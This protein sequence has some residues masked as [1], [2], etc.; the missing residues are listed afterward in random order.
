MTS[1]PLLSPPALRRVGTQR[2]VLGECPLWD[3][4]TGTLW[5]IDIRAPAL[6]RLDPQ[7]DAVS[8]WPLPELVGSLFRVVL[9]QP[10]PT[11]AA[12]VS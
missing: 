11:F 4:R 5:W 10:S 6:R 2:D 1:T 3:E 12:D 7:G 9:P 8:S